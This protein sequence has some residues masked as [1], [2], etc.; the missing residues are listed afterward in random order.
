MGGFSHFNFSDADSLFKQFFTSSG[1]DNEGD[2]EF[3]GSIFGKKKGKKGFGGGFGGF[4]M[5]DDDDFFSS[6]FGKGFGGM[7][8]FSSSSSNY[9]GGKHGISKSVSTVTKTVNG[10][11]VTTKKTTV[12]NPDGTKEVTEETID[13]GKK[14]E[15]K[16]SLG[17]GQNNGKGISYY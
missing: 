2:E 13:G 3:F 9:G 10:K 6:G 15:K 1:F 16:Y 12:V 7:S 11:T 4:S 8:S 17:P 14:L 5:F